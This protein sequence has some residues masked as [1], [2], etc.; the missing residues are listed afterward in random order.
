MSSG[1]SLQKTRSYRSGSPKQPL[2]TNQHNTYM[3]NTKNGTFL[4]RELVFPSS[5]V[6][7]AF[8][9]ASYPSIEGSQVSFAGTNTASR[10]YAVPIF[11]FNGSAG[12]PGLIVPI[13]L[14][15]GATP[16][17]AYVGIC[18]PPAI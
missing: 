1:L 5:L 13:A 3:Q 9:L 18:I 10:V 6:T 8:A 11:L 17:S 4:V 12:T 14:P 7:D 2:G 16:A 15:S